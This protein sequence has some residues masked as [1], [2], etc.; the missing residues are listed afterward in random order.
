[1]KAYERDM[2]DEAIEYFTKSINVLPLQNAFYSR[3]Q[4]YLKLNKRKEYCEDLN[5][6]SSFRRSKDLYSTFRNECFTTDTVFLDVNHVRLSDSLDHSFREIIAISELL[7]VKEYA[8]LDKNRKEMLS[9]CITDGDTVY[10][11]YNG[12]IPQFEG[13]DNKLVAFLSENIEYPVAA[14]INKI[15]GTV[16]VTFVVDQSGTVKDIAILKGIGAGC[17]E[18]SMRVVS[19]MPK[20]KP[21]EYEGRNISVRFNLPIRYSLR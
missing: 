18:E 7:E 4:A 16:Y 11:M 8:L 21:G 13:G 19:I 12:A 1:M 9:F 15:T 2:P 20:W 17:D 5:R 14:R 10:G 6:A 3:A